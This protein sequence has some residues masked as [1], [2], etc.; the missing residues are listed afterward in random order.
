VTAVEPCPVRPT[1]ADV[2]RAAGV[3]LATASRVLNG[4]PRVRAE[5]REQVVESRAEISRRTLERRDL[6][7]RRL[8][9]DRIRSIEREEAQH[10]M[11]RR[12]R[13][14]RRRAV[15]VEAR[16]E[17]LRERAERELRHPEMV[18]DHRLTQ[19]RIAAISLSF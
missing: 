19:Q 6:R 15:Y 7:Q 16:R 10:Q 2:A 11:I 9:V 14:A 8:V 3:S 13:Q 1:L 17:L 18:S 4:F 12:P 5:T